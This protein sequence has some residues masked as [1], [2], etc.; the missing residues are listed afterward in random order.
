MPID[1]FNNR[2]AYGDKKSTEEKMNRYAERIDHVKEFIQENYQQTIDLK[3][4]AQIACLSSF[5]FS[6]LFRSVTGCTPMQYVKTIRLEK[7]AY[8]LAHSALNISEV[9][10]QCGFNSISNFYSSFK[11]LYNKKPSEYRKLQKSKNKEEL[12]NNQKE[13]SSNNHHTLS[14]SMFRRIWDMNVT[15]KELP[16]YRIAF[17]RHIGSY[18]NTGEN[19]KRLLKWVEENKLF[20]RNP[21]FI[22]ISRDDPVKTEEGK[23]RHDACVTLP[24][25]FID[26]TGCRE[27]IYDTIASGKYA[28]YEFY[29]KIDRL[30]LV[31]R[32]LYS[33]WLPQSEYEPDTRPCLEINLN[34]PADD[35]EGKARC[36]I[37][38]SIK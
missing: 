37:C 35:P 8:Y 22:G 7:S 29:D 3:L 5:H 21:S 17:F 33:E 6:R 16:E 15:I 18:L 11:A 28:I 27:V 14:N 34:N 2:L 32:T 9:A 10:Y 25:G 19:W 1:N 38:I 26:A 36:H 30:A 31:Y 12:G 23:C 13:V 24:E 20:E 4:L